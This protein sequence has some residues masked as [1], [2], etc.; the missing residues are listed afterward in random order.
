MLSASYDSLSRCRRCSRLA[1]H[2]LVVRE[3]HPDYHCLPV[4]AWGSPH[5]RLLVVGLAPGMHGANRTGQPFTGDASG[6]FLFAAL[7]R[8]GLASN[9]DPAQARLRGVRITNAVKCLPPGNRPTTSELKEC[10]RFLRHEIEQLW[11]GQARKPRCILSLGRLAHQSV[12]YALRERLPDFRHG[13]VVQLKHNLWLADTYHPSRQNT[14]TGRLTA[15]MFDSVIG[16]VK[17]L[18]EG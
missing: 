1:D 16:C 13:S 18:V 4:G 5:A 10:S 17:G 2:L 12:G 11:S 15:E 6:S 8:H 9:P 7:S 3:T 14:N